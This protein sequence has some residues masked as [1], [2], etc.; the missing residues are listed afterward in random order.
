MSTETAA[1]VEVPASGMNGRPYVLRIEDLVVDYPSRD[2]DLRAVDGVSLE[3]REGET[4]GVVGESGCGKSTVALSVLG[5]ADQNGAVTRRGRVV[6]G[7][8]DI[9]A[10]PP[11]KRA[12]LRGSVAS[13]VFQEPMTAFNPLLTVGEQLCETL[14]AHHKNLSRADARIRAAELLDRVG[15]PDPQRRIG[16][17]P[18]E[19]SGGMLQRAMIAVAIANGPRLIVADEPATALDVTVQAQIIELFR[20]L[21]TQTNAGLVVVT[22]DLGIVAELVDR[23]VVMYAGKV[24]ETADVGTLF[25]EPRHPYTAALLASRPRL[26]LAFRKERLRSIPG[27]PVNATDITS[28]CAFR[29]RCTTWDG[30]DI[31]TRQAPPLQQI[32]ELRSAACHFHQ[33]LTIV[34]DR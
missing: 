20:E 15:V 12:A 13:L 28:G 25:T 10:R 33:E 18:S 1:A 4:I 7:D 11:A 2:G 27:A 23:V 16:Q 3:V 24:V 8:E 14:V 30:R 22:H 26:G 17:Y 6:V 34:E 29:P 19:F 21:T 5:L 31:C 9:L 32:G